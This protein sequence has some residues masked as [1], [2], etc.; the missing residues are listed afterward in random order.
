M[1]RS[2]YLGHEEAIEYIT[3]ILRSLPFDSDPYEHLQVE[4]SIHPTVLYRVSD[5]VDRN[6]RYL[7]EDMVASAIHHTAESICSRG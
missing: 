6:V 7:I 2:F 1:T 3:N 4:T 5:L